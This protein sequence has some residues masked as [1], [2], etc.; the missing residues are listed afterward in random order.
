MINQ[1]KYINKK[2]KDNIYHLL[3]KDLISNYSTPGQ[4]TKYN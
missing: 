3:N 4:L 2:L 1:L